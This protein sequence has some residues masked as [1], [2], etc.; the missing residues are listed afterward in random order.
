M[1]GHTAEDIAKEVKVYVGVFIA[2]MVLT[3]ATVAVSY[4]DLAIGKAIIVALMIA[5]I[6]GLLVAC[7]FMH[8]L[9]EKTIIYWALGITILFFAV[10]MLLPVLDVTFS[11][12]QAGSVV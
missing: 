5:S 10:L 2:L 7:Y 1:V 11:V 3:I 8:L 6:K 4:A 9:S 12:E